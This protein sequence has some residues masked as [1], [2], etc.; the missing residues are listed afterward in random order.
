[1]L[2]SAIE[3]KLIEQPFKVNSAVKPKAQLS[4]YTCESFETMSKTLEHH[5]KLKASLSK[6]HF[7]TVA[8]NL[9]DVRTP[10]SNMRLRF[11]HSSLLGS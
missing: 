8:V 5:Y 9:S 6:L 3:A 11:F 1:M 2:N 10:V 7:L 4:L